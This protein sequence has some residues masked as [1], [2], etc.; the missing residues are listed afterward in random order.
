MANKDIIDEYHIRKI[1]VKKNHLSIMLENHNGMIEGILK[2]NIDLFANSYQVNDKIKIQG[3][4]RKR[5]DEQFLDIIYVGK[6]IDEEDSPMYEDYR[7][8]FQNLCNQIKDKEYKKIIDSIFVDEILDLFLIYPAAQNRHHNYPHGLLQH[9]VETTEVAIYLCDYYK[10]MDRDLIITGGLLH[11][12][13]KLKCYDIK[14]LGD[15]KMII[16]TNWEHLL[17]HLSISAL[18]AS[19]IIPNDIGP[20]KMMLLYHM[21]LSSHGK[22]EWGSPEECKTKESYILAKADNISSVINGLNHAKYVRGWTQD[23]YKNRNWCKIGEID[24]E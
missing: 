11:D 24:D 15:K 12:I 20:K 7:I 5:K 16:K 18:F 14:D 1:E 22:R 23:K 17:G 2:D 6:S 8:R 3:R 13:G 4:L 21:I 9:T 19:K 10:E